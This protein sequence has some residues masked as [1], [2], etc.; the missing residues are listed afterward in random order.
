MN[1]VVGDGT[2]GT[3]NTGGA[4]ASD[5]GSAPACNTLGPRAVVKTNL[6]RW[7]PVVWSAHCR[8]VS[9]S[10]GQVDG[11]FVSVTSSPT[12]TTPGIC[13]AVQAPNVASWCRASAL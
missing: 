10:V 4:S 5:A 11:Q 2:V 1:G 13:T 3:T 9:F 6:S 12:R 7:H 8:R